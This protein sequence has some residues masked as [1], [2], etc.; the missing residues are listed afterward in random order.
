MAHGVIYFSASVLSFLLSAA[1]DQTVRLPLLCIIFP[2]K[3]NLP[4]SWPD[5]TL[6]CLHSGFFFFSPSHFSLFPFTRCFFFFNDVTIFLLFILLYILHRNIFIKVH[7]LFYIS[8][9]MQHWQL[10]QMM[11]CRGG[12][13]TKCSGGISIQKQTHLE[14]P[15]AACHSCENGFDVYMLVCTA[16]PVRR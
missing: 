9:N 12:C 15:S 7:V 6:K 11:K 5:T 8:V 14:P 10:Q 16:V 2:F 3:W 1:E 13:F 4:Y